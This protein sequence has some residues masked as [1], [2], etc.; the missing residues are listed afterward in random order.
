MSG[1]GIVAKISSKFKQFLTLEFF[2]LTFS[3]FLDLR[4]GFQNI[5]LRVHLINDLKII[6]NTT[7]FYENLEKKGD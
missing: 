1:I 3:T 5:P 6:G 7:N 2:T 4:I